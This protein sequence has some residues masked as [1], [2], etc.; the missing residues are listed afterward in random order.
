[1][2][3]DGLGT[4]AGKIEL[5]WYRKKTSQIVVLES[6]RNCWHS[7]LETGFYQEEDH[8]SSL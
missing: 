6:N 5:S 3:L 4:R 2:R 1:M 7:S 8:E